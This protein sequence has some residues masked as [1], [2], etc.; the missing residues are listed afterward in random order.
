M[1][2]FIAT[3]GTCLTILII[4]FPDCF[5][6][7]HTYIVFLSLLTLHVSN[8]IVFLC[9]STYVGQLFPASRDRVSCSQAFGR[10]HQ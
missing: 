1:L 7:L 10:V 2:R 9:G 6:T 3:S 4:I 8:A 5:L